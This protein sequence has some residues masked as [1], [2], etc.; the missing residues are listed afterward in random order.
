MTATN[1]FPP[2]LLAKPTAD[3]LAYFRGKVVAHPLLVNAYEQLQTL[4]REPAGVSLVFVFGP[5]GVGKSTLCQR[6]EEKIT[7]RALSESG[8]NPGR[9]SV[10]CVE[11]VAPETGNFNWKDFYHRALDACHEPLIEQKLDAV[12]RN[13]GSNS[14]ISLSQT[15]PS[16]TELSRAFESCL[17]HRQLDAF[18]IDEATHLGKV[19]SGRRQLDQMD[20]LKS[21]ANLTQTLLILVGTYE[22][23][24]LTNLNGQLSRRSADIEF[25]NYRFANPEDVRNY[26]GVLRTFE[27][28]LPLPSPPDLVTDYGYFYERSLGCVGILKD[29]LLRSLAD[30]LAHDAPTIDR[31]CLER[32]A[33]SDFKLL[34]N[35]REIQAGK[36][37]LADR[38]ERMGEIR[39]ALGMASAAPVAQPIAPQS[40][41]AR[42]G[43]RRPGRDPVGGK[44]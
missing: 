13:A 20:K 29:W 12:G 25:S 36:D 44:P 8:P 2:E 42:V 41:K 4:I 1:R 40:K 21:L 11:A 43:T 26:K 34:Q 33:L 10:V 19:T 37:L 17:K 18:I 24:H 22:L 31:A 39:A 9:I 3:R 32:N 7:E 6:L 15:K 23:L 30:A 16:L 27:Q 38:K 5:T 14:H 35:A 28:H